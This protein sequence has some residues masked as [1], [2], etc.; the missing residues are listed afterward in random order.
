MKVLKMFV[1]ALTVAAGAASVTAC[2]NTWDGA[3]KDV[4]NIGEEMQD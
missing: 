2:S 1:L 4:E 3:G